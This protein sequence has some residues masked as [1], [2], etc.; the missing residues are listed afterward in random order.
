M[1]HPEDHKDEK[2]EIRRMTM[3]TSRSPWFIR[4]S[5]E[6]WTLLCKISIILKLAGIT[7]TN[8]Q[9]LAVLN[10]IVGNFDELQPEMQDLAVIM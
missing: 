1:R 9:D 4:P 6:K 7:V 5:S 10:T 3:T 2:T 8:G